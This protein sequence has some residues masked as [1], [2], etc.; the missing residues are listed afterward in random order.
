MA[1]EALKK[2]KTVVF[3]TETVYGLGANALDEEAVAGIY[4]A[5]GRPLD[6]PLIIHIYKNTQLIYLVTEITER[7]RLLIDAFWPGPLTLVFNK[8]LSVPNSVTG[9]LNTVA[10][11]MPKHA[12]ARKLLSLVDLPIAAPSA[13]LSGKPSATK[14]KHV[15]NQLSDRVAVIVTD[16]DVEYGIESTVLDISG[17]NAVLLRPGSITL[18]AIKSIIGSVEVDK[19]LLK[20]ADL[21]IPKSPGMKYRHYAPE[22]EVYVLNNT[23]D[24]NHHLKVIDAFEANQK[25]VLYIDK[26]AEALAKTLYADLIEADNLGYDVVI[27]KAVTPIGVGLAVMN[28]LLKAAEFRIL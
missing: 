9:G 1:A 22:A 21:N 24:K 4:R 5:K 18:E 25:K 13:N 27:I 14:P 7:A 26:T 11:R 8:N 16:G 15:L 3:P 17:K 6:N 28:R 10:V 20:R 12:V 2:G 19:T 23:S